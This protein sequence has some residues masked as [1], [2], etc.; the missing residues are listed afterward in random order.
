MGNRAVIRQENYHQQRGVL[1]VR[2]RV[3]FAIHAQQGEIRRRV[4]NFELLGVG[5]QPLVGEG[6][7][8]RGGG[9]HRK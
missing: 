7:R 4:S 8:R 1:E 3:S 2:Q 9:V 5:G 6:F